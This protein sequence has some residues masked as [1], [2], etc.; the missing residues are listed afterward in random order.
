VCSRWFLRLSFHMN[1]FILLFL[2]TVTSFLLLV[3]QASSC[4]YVWRSR[5]PVQSSSKP[6]VEILTLCGK[7]VDIL[8]PDVQH[9]LSHPKTD[10]N[11]SIYAATLQHPSQC[12]CKI[13]QQNH[14]SAEFPVQAWTLS[15]CNLQLSDWNLDFIITMVRDRSFILDIYFHPQS[16]GPCAFRHINPLAAAIGVPFWWC[17]LLFLWW[18]KDNASTGW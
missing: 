15:I 8:R 10:P 3:K 14:G 18:C 12:W 17:T 13:V 16:Y 11:S 9:L 4:V 5:R 2:F 7:V 6:E 1:H